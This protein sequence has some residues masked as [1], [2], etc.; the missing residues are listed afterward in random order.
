MFKKFPIHNKDYLVAWW[1]DQKEKQGIMRS[2]PFFIWLRKNSLCAVE[3]V[4]KDPADER[5]PPVSKP[6]LLNE[7]FP[8][9]SP[10][11]NPWPQASPISSPFLFFFLGWSWKG[12]FHCTVKI[13]FFFSYF[14][15]WFCD[16]QVLS[17]TLTFT[18]RD[19]LCPGWSATRR[20]MESSSNH[21][22][23]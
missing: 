22:S 7:T 1:E 3:P 11:M 9:I 5:T 2:E 13:F 19:Q 14:N 6:L 12:R 21:A 16:H 20:C 15:S 4:M 10:R 17:A 18:A 23:C 8:F